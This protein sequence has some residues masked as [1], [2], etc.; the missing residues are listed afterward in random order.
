M[1]M[2][3]SNPLAHPPV[4]PT[5]DQNG[6]V[7]ETWPPIPPLDPAIVSVMEVWLQDH[8]NTARSLPVCAPLLAILCA[9]AEA[10][11]DHWVPV[12]ERLAAAVEDYRQLNDPMRRRAVRRREIPATSVHAI[13]AAISTAAGVGDIELVYRVEDGAVKRRGSVRSHRY[14][15]PSGKLMAVYRRG[16][17]A[18]MEDTRAGGQE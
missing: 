15:V 14:A 5:A 7:K 8:R 18:A 3:A 13:D 12:R 17:K 9:L 6:R 1:S 16:V 4:G 10:G 11:R 2:S